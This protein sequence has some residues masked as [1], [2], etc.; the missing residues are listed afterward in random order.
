MCSKQ[1]M[2]ETESWCR[3]QR[4][5]YTALVVGSRLEQWMGSLRAHNSTGLLCKVVRLWNDYAKLSKK[6]GSPAF[7]GS[8]GG[9]NAWT[10]S[11]C[12]PPSPYMIEKLLWNYQT[13]SRKDDRVQ[14]TQTARK[15][16][17]SPDSSNNNKHISI[18]KLKNRIKIKIK[19]GNVEMR[20]TPLNRPLTLIISYVWRHST[21]A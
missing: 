20:Q 18:V 2:A 21:L 12:Q 9:G 3:A 5:L 6:T 10:G 14:L 1:P 7:C 8:A 15:C 11:R 13:C 19:M 16:H 17:T 4:L